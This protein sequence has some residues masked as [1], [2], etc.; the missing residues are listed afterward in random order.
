[1][2]SSQV[3]FKSNIKFMPNELFLK[4]V[5]RFGQLEH[6]N[7]PGASK[8]IVRSAYAATGGI[9][10]CTAGGILVRNDKSK[11]LDV[12]MFHITPLEE[13]NSNFKIIERA[14][15]D[16]IGFDNPIQGFL[17][18]SKKILKFSSNMFAKFEILMQ[19]L[20]IPYSKFK[21]IPTGNADYVDLAYSAKDDQWS[22]FASAINHI[23]ADE[24]VKNFDEVSIS[25]KDKLIF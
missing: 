19:K 12:V 6:V 23:S 5:E 11:M 3:S 24:I 21:G 2:Q 25:E 4:E 9:K 1:M 20:N 14:I 17:L 13:A 22:V 7:Y 10:T 16:K 15:L 8:E 18:G